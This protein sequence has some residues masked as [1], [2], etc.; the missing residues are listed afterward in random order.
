[1]SGYND[2]ELKNA[3]I[4]GI[5]DFLKNQT[6]DECPFFDLELKYAWQEGWNDAKED[7]Q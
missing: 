7:M 3:F 1:M 4:T 5:K 2:P 6:K